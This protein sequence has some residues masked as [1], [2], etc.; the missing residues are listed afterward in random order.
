M[1]TL[2]R[3]LLGLSLQERVIYMFP[4][5]VRTNNINQ[6]MLD[7]RQPCVYS[8]DNARQMKESVTFSYKFS[9]LL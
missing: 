5:P 1:E 4:S 3:G 2:K 9:E 7:F 6:E 8:V